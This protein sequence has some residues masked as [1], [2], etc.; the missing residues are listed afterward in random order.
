MQIAGNHGSTKPELI[1]APITQNRIFIQYQG[2]ELTESSGSYIIVYVRMILFPNTMEEVQMRYKILCV[3]IVLTIIFV[4]FSA[5]GYQSDQIRS[6]PSTQCFSIRPTVTPE[7]R[8][9]RGLTINQSW[10]DSE[11]SFSKDLP[12][13][14]PNEQALDLWP[15]LATEPDGTLHLVWFNNEEGPYHVYYAQSTDGGFSWSDREKVDDMEGGKYAKFPSVALDA[16]ANVYATW[17][18]DRKGSIYDVFFS[19]RIW[20]GEKWEWTPSFKVNT[21]GSS[22]SPADWMHATI[23]AGGE[24][25][26]IVAWVDWREGVYHQIYSRRSTDGGQTWL[27]EVK[28]SHSP[29]ENPVFGQPVLTIDP[30]DP[31]CSTVYCYFHNW[32]GPGW[33]FPDCAFSR[34]D[35]GGENWCER[36]IVNDITNY[37]QQNGSRSFGVDLVGNL[38]GIWYNDD[39]FGGPNPN[40]I[41]VSR[42]TDG[43]LTWNSGVTASDPMASVSVPPS[44]S[45]CPGGNLYAL[46]CDWRDLDG[47]GRVAFSYSD[48]WGKRWSD[49]NYLLGDPEAEWTYNPTAAAGPGESFTT[50]FSDYRSMYYDLYAVYGTRSDASLLLRLLPEDTSLSP[51]DV[52][53]YKGAAFNLTDAP[54]SF[55]IRADVFLPGG[56]PYP[57]NPVLGPFHVTMPGYTHALRKPAH[58][59]PSHAPPGTYRYVVTATAPPD[60]L[61][62]THFKFEVVSN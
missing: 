38:F 5:P 36:I 53:K 30:F 29:G 28:I 56:K 11:W 42:S 6:D 51:G 52:L 1:I 48:D 40:D 57:L 25:F 3:S 41:R 44:L 39:D 10:L 61:A 2:Y 55:W 58:K 19:K 14:P 12:V 45:V 22:T 62:R 8:A 49:P 17:E 60:T 47:P 16:E 33:R 59:I 43:G 4:P 27:D 31:T 20:N 9:V 34:S 54:V 50:V 23:S 24:G 21:S 15:E 13:H 46:W 26:V 35:D 7:N 37:F 18:D 32:E